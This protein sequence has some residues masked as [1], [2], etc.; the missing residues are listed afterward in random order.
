MAVLIAGDPHWNDNSRDAYRHNWVAWF[1]NQVRRP[2]V[3]DGVVLLGDLT[4]AK[5][6]HSGWLTNKV[7]GH[8][9]DIAKLCPVAVLMGNHDFTDPLNA[10]FSFT[11]KIEN[12]TWIGKPRK[13]EAM[14]IAGAMGLEQALFLPFTADYKRDWKEFDLGRYAPIFTHQTFSGADAGYG[15][16]LKGIPLDIFVKSS[17]VISGDVHV[18]QKLGP[19]TY[20][21]SPYTINFGD[22]FVGRILVLERGKLT[23][24]P[25]DGPQKKLAEITDA[26]ELAEFTDIYEGDVLKVNVNLRDREKW[27]ETKA[28][29]LKWGEKKKVWIFSVVPVMAKRAAAVPSKVAAKTDDDLFKS[30]CRERSLA[31]SMVKTGKF[32]MGKA[33]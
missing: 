33:S 20:A 3:A 1:L 4:E 13:G 30:F 22:S 29:V 24:I 14:A 26:S 10:F 8:I 19:V 31:D 15:Q 9:H 5:D 25:Y 28:A 12:V 11:G 7:V 18:P 17:M 2:R 21:G 32:L 16:K 27:A 6:R 23:S